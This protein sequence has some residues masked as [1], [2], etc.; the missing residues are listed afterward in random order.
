MTDAVIHPDNLHDLLCALVDGQ[1]TAAEFDALHQRLLTDDDAMDQ[2][3]RL[4]DLN[5]ELTFRCTPSPAA[6]S[7]PTPTLRRLPGGRSVW[8]FAAAALIALTVTAWFALFSPP[9]SSTTSTPQSRPVALISEL[10]NAVFA[11]QQ[12]PMTPGGELIAGPIE[13]VSGSA[14]VMFNS[15]AMV[16]LSG[17]CS[18]RM[19]DD[20]RAL[21]TRGRLEAHVPPAARGFIIE[22]PDGTRLIDRGTRFRV[23]LESD[24]R[25][26][27]LVTEGHV[28]IVTGSKPAHRLAA[29]QF[30]VIDHRSITRLATL[31]ATGRLDLAD[32]LAGGDGT[33]DRAAMLNPADGSLR[34]V[35]DESVYL[36]GDGKYHPVPASTLIDGVFIPD[37]SRGPMTLDSAGHQFDGFGQTI[38]KSWH[39]IW[40]G[41]A[42]N[43]RT[44]LTTIDD[45]NYLQPPH[46]LVFMHPNKGVTIDL[47]AVRR[48]HPGMK[49]VELTAVAAC[50]LEPIEPGPATA[51]LYV[52]I[53]GTP[54]L[55][56]PQ[57]RYGDA[58]IRLRV[59]LRDGDRFLT[60][61]TTDGG[62][63][64]RY[65]W[66][67]LGDAKLTYEQLAPQNHQTSTEGDTP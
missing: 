51:G 22:L 23:T 13:L 31:S 56:H 15:T 58:P 43:D 9:S 20:N 11:S 45:T 24:G 64:T 66:V 49:L 32:I 47:D 28:D 4:V 27:V 18:F 65:D 57:M 62:D 53:D 38:G 67:M 33:G 48:V 42:P 46:R 6:A 8:Y 55:T 17:P 1:L 37:G 25:C 16:D 54:R 52:F 63:T 60:L 5:T 40:A 26:E 29:G 30:A 7:A 10:R 21:L 2:Y 19:I 59:A 50:T 39:S 41:A 44:D 14:Q 61:A 12:A 36:Q 35:G 3:L 34:P